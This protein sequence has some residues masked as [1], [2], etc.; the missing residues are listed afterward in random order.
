MKKIL[1][2]IALLLIASQMIYPQ[3]IIVMN[4]GSVINAYRTDYQGQFVYYQA[5]DSDSAPILRVKKEDVL[6][7]RLADGTAVTPNIVQSAQGND[8]T[9]GEKAQPARNFP[10]IDLT[11]YHGF[12]LDKGNCVYVTYNSKV[13]Y[14]VA[15]VEA[16]KEVIEKDGLWQ[17][18]DK[19]SQA[20][21]VLQ[22]CVTLTGRDFARLLLRP[23]DNYE[24][25]PF[26]SYASL[27]GKSN[28]KF[29]LCGGDYASDEVNVCVNVANAVMPPLLK[30]YAAALESS[31]FMESVKMGKLIKV[32]G[33]KEIWVLVNFVGV[34]YETTAPSIRIMHDLFYR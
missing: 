17:V 19:P 13:D 21:F 20:H 9:T 12:L 24:Q 34:R 22:F 28:E 14:E 23:R 16:I 33:S 5:D 3:D 8:Q 31:N 18:V 6:V 11:D 2:L 15:A 10:D 27:S 32:K 26:M 4:D 25:F 7:I 1:T 30:D 29:Y